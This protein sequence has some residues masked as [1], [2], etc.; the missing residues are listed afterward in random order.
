MVY[1]KVSKSKAQCRLYGNIGT[2]MTNGETFTQ[3]LEELSSAGF[4][5]LEF[6]EHCYGGSVFEGNVMMNAV[7]SSDID[8]S[9]LIEGLA[10]SFGLLFLLSL[11]K[12]KVSICENAFG[13]IHRPSSVTAGDADDMLSSANLM[14]SMEKNMIPKI[15]ERSGLTEDEV[16]AKWFDGKDHWLNA[17]EMVQYGFAGKKVKP[18]AASIKSLDKQIVEQSTPE[19]IYARFAAALNTNPK[20]KKTMDLTL[21]IAT[22]SLEGVTAESTDAAVLAALQAKFKKISDKVDQLESDISAKAK[23]AITAVLDQ[24]DADKKF[25]GITG[26][27]KE[28]VRAKY[29]DLGE[30][31]GVEMLK[32]VL[33]G[34]KGGTS[35]PTIM[36]AVIPGVGT[37]VTGANGAT[38]VQNWEWYQK[39]NPAALEAMKVENHPDHETF[40]ELYKAEYGSYPG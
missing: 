14:Q 31:A 15:S 19:T 17:E 10:A 18:V 34:L 13:M 11:P 9:V 4:T 39:N 38:V 7:E 3:M 6:R 21:L 32:M 37:S 16:K 12:E 30:K 29:L 35:K 27:T 2:W 24:A 22:F 20:N 36:Q 33:A 28:Q 1:K 5:E 26:M 23:D 25:E 40:K 8:I